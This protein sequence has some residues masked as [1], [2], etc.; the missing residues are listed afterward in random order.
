MELNI[1]QSVSDAFYRYKMPV[2]AA[3]V[4]GKGNGIKTVIVNVTEIAKCLYR[5]PIYVTKYFGCELGT[6]IHV[7]EKNDRYIV[8]GAH[9][10]SRLQEHLFGFIKKFVLCSNCGNPETTLHVKPKAAIVTTTCAACGH[11]DQLDPRHRLTQFIIKNP[12][13]DSGTTSD[14][15][16]KKSAAKNGGNGQANGDADEQNGTGDSQSP[17]DDDDVD[18]GED[19]TEEAQKQRYA[20]L[21]DMVKYLTVSADVDKPDSERADIFFKLISGYKQ[22]NDV[23]KRGTELRNEALR[24]NLGTRAVL[25]VGEVLLSDPKTV[26]E[27]IKKYKPVLIQFTRYGEEKPKAQG[28]MLGVVASLVEKHEKVLFPKAAHIIHALY[29]H[30][31][32]EEETIFTWFDKNLA[33]RYVSKPMVPRFNKACEPFLTWLKTAEEE[34]DEGES[35]DKEENGNDPQVPSNPV[36]ASP[37]GQDDQEESDDELDIDAI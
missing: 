7:D 10:A 18:W 11:R 8:N 4:E 37:N 3:K 20:E 5:K 15:K 21:S 31:I 1:N 9:D 12:P 13:E 36:S 34:S 30:D 25:I 27:D 29:D 22:N 32:V 24:L 16:G 2:L 33:K 6:Q 26:I 35:E 28:Y 23:S 14:K 17:S 19:T